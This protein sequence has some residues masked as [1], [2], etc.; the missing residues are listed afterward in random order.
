MI[1]GLTSIV[2]PAFNHAAY[3][4]DAIDSALAQTAMVEVIV[5]DD[6]STD[7]T[8]EVLRRYNDGNLNVLTIAHAGVAVARNIG[9]EAAEGEF[10][11]FLDADDGI[12]PD[13]VAKQ[14]AA[15]DD[16]SGWVLCDVRI[17]EVSGKSVNASSRYHY[18]DKELSG[19]IQSYL[20]VANF[21]PI[22]SPLIRR[23]ALGDIRFEL[24]RSPEDWYF[25]HAMAGSARCKY[26]PEVLATYRK[27]A[28]G[29]NTTVKPHPANAPGIVKPL[30]LNLG[31]GT[32]HTRS[33]HP[34]A[35]MVNLDRSLGWSFED[36]LGDFLDGSVAG[37]T[38]SHALMYVHLDAWPKVFAEF[39]R[40]LQP[41]GILRITEDDTTT[42]GSSRIGG[43]Q[44]SQPAVTLTD[45]KMARHF[46]ETAGFTVHDV[47][48]EST[49]YADHSLIQ[50]QHGP[51]PDCFWIEG[52]REQ[53]ILFSPHPDD[54]SL[55]ASFTIIRH[56][57]RVVICF[58]STGD[59]GDTDTRAS[60]SRKAVAILGGGPVEQWDGADLEAKMRE[61]DGRIRPT[62][63][64]A[65]SA[66][67]SHPDHVAVA[68]A[69][70]AVFG[71]RLTTFH[72][73]KRQLPHVPDEM[74]TRADLEL[75]KYHGT[76]KVRDG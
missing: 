25:W 73:Y 56:K 27:R 30:R 38:V 2:I 4:P 33:W 74:L 50:A 66:N 70:G 7:G 43:W 20:A 76:G 61:I 5:V 55:F 22:M 60:E 68:L 63:V 72:T 10:V 17:E 24:G 40:V 16:D 64:W 28:G 48:A 13:K 42:P 67:S 71:R 52:E 51:A 36:G 21:I 62:R 54:E 8:R 59:Y 32:P 23:K 18:S 44:G 58:G 9:I 65:P 41:G 14:L 47:S 75:V 69:A 35:G 12:A 39:A 26:V 37:I 29:R 15:L 3:L 31:C 45:A 34:I 11:M 49:K 19:W 57:P 53:T 6:G 1:P 46:L